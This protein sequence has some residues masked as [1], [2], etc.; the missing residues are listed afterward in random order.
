MSVDSLLV[1]PVAEPVSVTEAKAHCNIT[2]SGD[3]TLVADLIASAR[4]QVE[5]RCRRALVRQQ[6]KLTLDGFC[7]HIVLPVTPLRAVQSIQYLDAGGTLQTLSSAVYRVNKTEPPTITLEYGQSW[8]TV[9]D[10]TGAVIVKYTA[11]HVVPIDSFDASADTLTAAGHDLAADD[12]VQLSGTTLPGGTSA[13]ATYYVKSPAADTL[14]LSA[15][16]G[17]AA[18]NLTAATLSA[19]FIGRL[20]PE[21]KHAIL[22]LVG[23]AYEHREAAGDFPVHEIPLG[24]ERLLAPWRVI[25]F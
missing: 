4:R 6:R 10:V 14:Q 8:P 24:V 2:A 16:E 9:R 11:G 17:G 15:T 18:L 19:A 23:H 25:G 3:D 13:A 7:G 1:A 5:T 22:L 12:P 20:E 21:I